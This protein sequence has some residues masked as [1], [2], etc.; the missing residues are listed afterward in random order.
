MEKARLIRKSE[1]RTVVRAFYEIKEA[2]KWPYNPDYKFNHVVIVSRQSSFTDEWSVSAYSATCDGNTIER[3]KS[4]MRG[5]DIEA[6]LRSL[7][8]EAV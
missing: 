8:L 7:E 3:I 1:S 6:M 5:R 4:P 2:R